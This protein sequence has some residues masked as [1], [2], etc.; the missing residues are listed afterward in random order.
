M[1]KLNERDG[2][3][4]ITNAD[5]LDQENETFSINYWCKMKYIAPSIQRD[6]A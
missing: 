6:I 4:A 2:A 1:G 3:K 5:E